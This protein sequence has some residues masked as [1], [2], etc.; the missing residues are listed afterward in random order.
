MTT[1]WFLIGWRGNVQDEA[2]A[3]HYCDPAI[4]STSFWTVLEVVGGRS[5]EEAVCLHVN[6][7]FPYKWWL[8][9]CLCWNMKRLCVSGQRY[10]TIQRSARSAYQT[11]IAFCT[12]FSANQPMLVVVRVVNGHGHYI[13]Y[14]TKLIVCVCVCEC[15]V[16]LK[17]IR[18]PSWNRLY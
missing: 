7:P 3:C 6:L 1:K 16:E 12:F 17:V 14:L 11:R 8:H 15:D 13:I 5:R 18:Q 2:H 10:S 9:V 4:S